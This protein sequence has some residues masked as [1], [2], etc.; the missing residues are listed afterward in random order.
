VEKIQSSILSTIPLWKNQIVIAISPFRQKQALGIVDI[1]TL[2]KVNTDLIA[3][4]E[5]TLKIQREGKRKR[6]E[7]E[8]ELTRMERELKQT[9]Q[10][11]Q[12]E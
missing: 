1:E 2:A 5:E 10:H 8:R 12:G 7:A 3:T 11:V 4:I 6:Q 9:L